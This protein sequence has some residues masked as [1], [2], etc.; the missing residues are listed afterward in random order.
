MWNKNIL[1]IETECPNFFVIFVS[2]GFKTQANK[3]NKKIL[4]FGVL[5]IYLISAN[6]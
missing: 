4:T 6:L 2:L 1:R 5:K 3:N